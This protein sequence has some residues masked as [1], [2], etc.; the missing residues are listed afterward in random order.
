MKGGSF[1]IV[2]LA[3]CAAAS[4]AMLQGAFDQSDHRRALQAVRGYTFG[5]GTLAAFLEAR[6]PRGH[7]TTEITHSCRGVVRTTYDAPL[8]RYEFDY[9]V[10]EHVIHPA[11][12]LGR[13]AL[14]SFAAA[15]LPTPRAGGAQAP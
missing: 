1:R 12:E 11:N 7:W 8:A 2:I 3:F 6:A 9:V 15:K 4:V 13:E 5:S 10:P 14:A